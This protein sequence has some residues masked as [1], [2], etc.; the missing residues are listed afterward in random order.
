MTESEKEAISSLNMISIGDTHITLSG[1]VA[2]N[3]QLAITVVL[4]FLVLTILFGEPL[5][6]LPA[7]VR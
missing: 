3:P 5:F 4:L 7:A 1:I 6:L 2:S